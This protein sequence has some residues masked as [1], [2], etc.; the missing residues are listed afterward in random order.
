[1]E[2]Q[3][4]HGNQSKHDDSTR[5]PDFKPR[6]TNIE[7]QLRMLDDDTPS[8]FC[9]DSVLGGSFGVLAC[10]KP[11]NNS[12]D[13]LHLCCPKGEV[14]SDATK[15]KCEPPDSNTASLMKVPI[16]GHLLDSASL[17]YDPN[18]VHINACI[19][20]I[21]YLV[22]CLY[23]ALNR[24]TQATARACKVTVTWQNFPTVFVLAAL[25]EGYLTSDE[26]TPKS[27]QGAQTTFALGFIPNQTILLNRTYSSVPN[28]GVL[29]MKGITTGMQSFVQMTSKFA[30]Y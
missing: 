2:S 4:E 25:M 13:S 26:V 1:M 18:K 12:V 10:P 27:F 30:Y 14:F 29:S 5:R 3:P 15:T 6:T 17:K 24:L 20:D 22:Q 11:S 9:L 23:D 21:V 19:R 7:I 8:F 28:T 16:D